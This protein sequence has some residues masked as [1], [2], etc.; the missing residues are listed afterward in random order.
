[1][2]EDH[3]VWG[4]NHARPEHADRVANA[5]RGTRT[6]D[7]TPVVVAVDG[8]AGSGK[9]SLAALV[10]DRLDD[11]ARVHL[12]D[13]FPGWDGLASA[14][15]LLAAQVLAPLSRREPAAYRRFDWPT[16][17]YA[18]LVPVPARRF[19]V[20]EGCSST[21]GIAR[22]YVDVRVWVEA[23]HDTRMRRGLERS[24]D[25]FGPNWERWARQEEAVFAADRTREHAHLIF[26]TDGDR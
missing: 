20:V 24:G 2:T 12:D 17:R 23:E 3:H 4:V 19:V 5:A 25:E 13:V 11:V 26:R 1:M 10:C 21:V 6:D 14:P 7:D 16:G 8:P 18:E 15:A 22:P 9:S